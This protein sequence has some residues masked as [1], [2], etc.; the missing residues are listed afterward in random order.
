MFTLGAACQSKHSEALLVVD[1]RFISSSHYVQTMQVTSSILYIVYFS[2][3]ISHLHL[4]YCIIFKQLCKHQHL[5]SVSTTNI[6]LYSI[7]YH[8]ARA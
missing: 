7:L 1:N 6:V 8:D 3:P 2:V 4:E 5:R